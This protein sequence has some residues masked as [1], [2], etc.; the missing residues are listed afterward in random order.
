LKQ[1]INLLLKVAKQNSPFL[2]RGTF[3]LKGLLMKGLDLAKAAN[4]YNDVFAHARK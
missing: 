3:G 2:G 4:H 1:V